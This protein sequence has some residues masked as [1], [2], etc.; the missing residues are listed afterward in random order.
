MQVSLSKVAWALGVSED[1]IRRWEREGRILKATR[2]EGGHRRWDADDVLEMMASSERLWSRSFITPRKEERF[3]AA[4]WVA[5]CGVSGCCSQVSNATLYASGG[6]MGRDVMF[7]C[8]DH[9]GGQVGGRCYSGAADGS[10]VMVR[11]MKGA[12]R[13]CVGAT[14]NEHM[15][16]GIVKQLLAA[17][18]MK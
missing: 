13:F 12:L 11:T 1:T 16:R 8:E 3:E 10:T 14:R 4:R 15:V 7:W 9:R 2:T 6:D 17:K 18:G 5:S